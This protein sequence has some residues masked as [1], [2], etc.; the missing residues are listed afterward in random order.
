MTAVDQDTAENPSG[1]PSKRTRDGDACLLFDVSSLM[2]NPKDGK[3]RH[4]GID[5]QRHRCGHRHDR[6]GMT[7]SV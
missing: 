3:H 1:C 6:V 5:T 4:D 7:V 2:V